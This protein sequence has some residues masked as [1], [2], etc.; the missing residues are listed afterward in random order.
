MI[1]KVVV[2]IA[3]VMI[4]SLS[5]AGC[6]FSTTNTGSPS[7]SNSS[8]STP[9]PTASVGFTVGFTITVSFT[10]SVAYAYCP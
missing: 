8:A 9:S 2:I 6:L 4:A 5:A 10:V 7:V 3:L 1:K